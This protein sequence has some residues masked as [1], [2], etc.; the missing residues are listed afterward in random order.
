MFGHEEKNFLNNSA[1]IQTNGMLMFTN[2]C[3]YGINIWGIIALKNK[4]HDRSRYTFYKKNSNDIRINI[5]MR[6][7]INQQYILNMN[8]G[9]IYNQ[10]VILLQPSIHGHY[11]LALYDTLKTAYEILYAGISNPTL[12]KKRSC[13]VQNIM[14]R[15]KDTQFSISNVS[16]ITKLP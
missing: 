4:Q 7:L 9:Q 1:L 15:L 8:L 13:R 16:I 2:L 5:F 6:N 14:K 12:Q 10:K 3:L 11:I